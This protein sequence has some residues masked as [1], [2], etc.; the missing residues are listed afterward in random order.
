[1]CLASPCTI[2]CCAV[3]WCVQVTAIDISPDKEQEAKKL[4]ARRSVSLDVVAAAVLTRVQ[5][6]TLPAHKCTYIL[7]RAPVVCTSHLPVCP[8]LTVPARDVAYDLCPQYNN[9][10]ISHPF[11]AKGCLPLAPCPARAAALC[12]HTQPSIHNM[13]DEDSGDRPHAQHLISHSQ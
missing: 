6:C 2:P 8:L 10:N 13:P 5:C 12:Q 3:L 9:N 1:M 7:S 4:G 11:H